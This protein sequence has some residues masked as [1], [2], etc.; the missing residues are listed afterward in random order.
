MGFD[1]QVI[2]WTEGGELNSAAELFTSAER[3]SPREVASPKQISPAKTV[4][5][6]PVQS[7][8]PDPPQDSD[9]TDMPSI[10]A[11]WRGRFNQRFHEGLVRGLGI[12]GLGCSMTMA[13][14]LADGVCVSL[15]AICAAMIAFQILGESIA[16]VAGTIP[17]L[18]WQWFWLRHYRCLLG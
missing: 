3:L 10:G 12:K 9:A 1:Y 17:W 13:R 2:E 7:E 18:A 6:A 5:A 14:F 4:A 15:Y 16:A 8:P 11:R